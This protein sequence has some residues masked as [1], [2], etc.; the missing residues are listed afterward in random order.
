[1]IQPAKVDKDD[2]LASVM[3]K[4]QDSCTTIAFVFDEDRAVGLITLSNI[5]EE[6]MGVKT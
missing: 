4:T 3:E 1:M 6:V 5:I 2:R